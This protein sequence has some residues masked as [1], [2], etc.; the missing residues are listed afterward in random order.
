M[1]I[2]AYTALLYGEDYLASAIRSIIDHVD[3][4]YVFYTPVGSHG[5]R[6]DVPCPETEDELYAIAAEAAGNKL[7]WHRGIWPYEGAQ[8]DFIH[9]VAPDADM[10]IVLDADEIWPDGLA[11][12][13]IE[14]VERRSKQVQ[15]FDDARA[16]RVPMKHFWRSF[17]RAVLRDPAFPVR[18]IRPKYSGGEVTYTGASIAHMGYAQRSE[19][20]QYKLLTHGHRGE[21]RRDCDWF[22][23]VF[24]ANRQTNCHPVGSEYWNPEPVNPLDYMPSWMAEHPYFGLEVIP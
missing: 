7:R 4:Y 17:Y 11:K 16:I 10:I 19:I 2:V 8:R 21:F 18:V 6:T 23:D 14:I 3:T 13:I 12:H 15:S 1:N 5:H 20:V 9:E 24:M 22:N